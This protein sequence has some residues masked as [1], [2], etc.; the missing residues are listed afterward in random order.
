[1][2][3]AVL[4]ERDGSTWTFVLNRPQKRNA[5]NAEMVEAL[6]AGVEHA[7]AQQ[8][9]LLVFRGQ[10]KSFCAGFDF[11]GFDQLSEGDLLWRFVRIEQLLQAID[12]SPC[13]TVALA[14][15]ANFGAGV[16]LLVACKSRVAQPD[17]SFRMP[18]LKFGLLL[19][20]RRLALRIG[21]EHARQ[22]QQV[23]A[24]LSAQEAMSMG[25]LQQIIATQ[26]WDSWVKQ[27]QSVAQALEP[28]ARAA[29]Y[30]A[31]RPSHDKEDMA[32]LVL[33]VTAAGLKDRIA[34][35][36]SAA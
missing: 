23:A 31:L 28:A 32:D 19:G 27:Q 30:S 1:M 16:D 22:V 13:L 7:H 21:A 14:Q 10:G 8:A 33:S 29:L 5:L 12:R 11:S 6:M 25:L 36:R 2:S 4:I 35:Y 9:E 20:T 15:G 3:E 34:R 17:A 26:E 18:G 24:T